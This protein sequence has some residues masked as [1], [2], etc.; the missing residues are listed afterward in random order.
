M[1]EIRFLKDLP[2][3]LTNGG[4]NILSVIGGDIY[5]DS[6]GN[7][8]GYVT[9]SNLNKSPIFA[10]QLALKE[11][12]IDGKFIKENE[13][14]EPYT[15][16]EKGQFV[17]KE[18]IILD[19]ETEALEITIIKIT[20]DRQH[21]VDNHLV[22]FK[23]EDYLPVSQSKVPYKRTN[24][25][26]STFTFNNRN[27]TNVNNNVNNNSGSTNVESSNENISLSDQEIN[28]VAKEQKNF[29]K[30]VFPVV[31]AIILGIAVFI[32][33][34]TVSGGVDAF[35]NGLISLIGKF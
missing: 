34:S 3:K 24:S 30:I 14:F 28:N 4:S 31:G 23:N 13:Y 11:F 17:N 27:N 29:L 35:N 10:I 12:N 15:Y 25:S 20:F 18:P 26:N 16:Y 5:Y 19:K 32:I 21:Y 2:L 8:Y 22:N 33:M 1:K 6:E 9:F 7:R